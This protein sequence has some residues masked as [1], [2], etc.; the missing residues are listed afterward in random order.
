MFGLPIAV[1]RAVLRTLLTGGVLAAALMP[2]Q[3]AW[4]AGRGSDASGT[5]YLAVVN[6]S[7]S[8]E[9]IEFN[10]TPSGQ[11]FLAL[12]WNAAAAPP[13]EGA[14]T[15]RFLVGG[16][17]LF[18]ASARLRLLDT[19]WAAAELN[20]PD[21]IAPLTE[22]LSISRGN[23][24]VSVVGGG[25]ALVEAAFDLDA[26]ALGHGPL[27]GLL[28]HVNRSKGAEPPQA[29]VTLSA[30]PV[31][32]TCYSRRSGNQED[33]MNRIALWLACGIAGALLTFPASAAWTARPM[34]DGHGHSHFL[35]TSTVDAVRAELF[36]SPEGV[37]NFAL[38]WPDS[39]HADAA[40]SD[41]PATLTI[42]TDQGETFEAK[43]YYWASGK[44]VLILDFGYPPEVRD[45]ARA[46]GDA[47]SAIT[48]TVDDPT[49]DIAKQV[50]Y[51]TE[52]AA[53]AMAAFLAWCPAPAE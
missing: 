23:F 1:L 9:R 28:P 45:L 27:P 36:C 35:A 38:V 13:G 44:G 30:C 33:S 14:L 22:V 20:T 49:N 25:H 51:D 3:G 12:T 2:A 50:V 11:A 48:V 39:A 32:R 40:D 31:T 37:V 24:E 17:H 46:I 53:E 6:D 4:M 41:Q 52:G 10:C 43:S 8:G 21:I 5:A 34:S 47:Q 29:L 19:G 26:A 15:L 7:A 16:S 18:A 42:T